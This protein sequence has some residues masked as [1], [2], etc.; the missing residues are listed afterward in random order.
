MSFTTDELREAYLEFF[1][2]QNHRRLPS[3]GLAPSDPTMMFTSA[4]MVQF[5]DIF[6]GRREP[7]DELVTTCQKCF[8]A[9]DIER[10]GQTAYHHTFFEMLGNFSFGGYFKEGAIELAWE[11]VTEVLSMERDRLWVSVY[12]EDDRAYR[13]WRDHIGVPEGRIVRLGKEEN[14]WGPVGESGPC[15]PDSE[16]FYDAG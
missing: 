14:W 8:R 7:R 15:G 3:S 11:F 9:T 12:E 5:K 2:R 13:L 10:V 6:W 16:L 1:E 4:G